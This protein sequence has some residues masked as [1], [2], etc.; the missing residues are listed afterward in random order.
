MLV[1]YIRFF[2]FGLLLFGLPAAMAWIT[3]TH[4][5][6]YIF[7]LFA[8]LVIIQIRSI[9]QGMQNSQ[10]PITEGLIVDSHKFLED[11]GT[12]R[13]S[14]RVTYR[15]FVKAKKYFNNVPSLKQDTEMYDLAAAE[16]FLDKYPIGKIVEVHYNPKRPH[17]SVLETG[18][19]DDGT[20]WFVL[21]LFIMIMLGAGAWLIMSKIIS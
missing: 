12:G 10:W 17:T 1:R 3:H 20:P 6:G 2:L 19:G 15:Y 9:I 5:A 4:G 13:Y 14:I 16:A 18:L 21:V 11:I 8:L 7:F